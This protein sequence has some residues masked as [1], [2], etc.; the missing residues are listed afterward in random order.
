M[1]PGVLMNFIVQSVERKRKVVFREMVI[2][3][4]AMQMSAMRW[5]DLE[6]WS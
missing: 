1:Q 5:Q 3:L 2:I 6:D 4:E